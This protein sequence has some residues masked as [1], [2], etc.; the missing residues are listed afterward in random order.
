MGFCGVLCVAIGCGENCYV[1]SVWFV[2]LQHNIV[3]WKSSGESPDFEGAARVG[4]L[5]SLSKIG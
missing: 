1:V 2:V 3:L 4:E 5:G